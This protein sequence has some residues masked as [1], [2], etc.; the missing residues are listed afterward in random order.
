MGS[1]RL[2]IRLEVGLQ[3][4]QAADDVG[5]SGHGRLAREVRQGA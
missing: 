5:A 4:P 3:M 2:V 1:V